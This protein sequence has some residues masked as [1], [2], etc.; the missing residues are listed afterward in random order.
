MTGGSSGG[1]VIWEAV[2]LNN[3]Q[4]SI[5][6]GFMGIGY[7]HASLPKGLPGGGRRVGGGLMKKRD[8]IA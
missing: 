4:K 5:L 3:F 8:K 2:L 1:S 7:K 6:T